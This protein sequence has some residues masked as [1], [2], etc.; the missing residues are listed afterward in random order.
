MTRR[1][2]LLWGVPA[3]LGLVVVVIVTVLWLTPPDE[4][5]ERS[6]R[7]QPEMTFD[8]VRV[9]LGGREKP[10]PVVFPHLLPQYDPAPRSGLYYWD[11][12]DGSELILRFEDDRLKSWEERRATPWYDD[13]RRFFQF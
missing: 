3:V 6:N 8:K 13:L 10:A 2:L 11:F 1:K 5:G 12:Q 7:L 9:V 4:A